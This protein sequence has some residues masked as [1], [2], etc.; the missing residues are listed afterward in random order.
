MSMDAEAALNALKKLEANKTCVNCGN[1]N[2]FGHQNICE[3]VRTFVC[4]NC[5]SAHQSYSMRVKSVSMSNWTMEEVDALRE[6][7]G[8][9][10]AVAAR[11][12]LRRWNDTEM[13][14]PTKDD[15]LDYYKQFINHV[16]NEKAFYSDDGSQVATLNSPTATSSGR[17]AASVCNLLDFDMPDPTNVTHGGVKTTKSSAM[18]DEW[19]AF[20][21]VPVPGSANDG[22]GAFASAPAPTPSISSDC[23]AGTTALRTENDGFGAFASAPAVPPSSSFD[24]FAVPGGTVTTPSV[25]FDPFAPT[26]TQQ[27]QT[28]AS[29]IMNQ[30]NAAPARVDFSVF[31]ALSAP[32]LAYGTPQRNNNGYGQ[33]RGPVG[34]SMGTG[35]NLQQRGFQLQQHLQQQSTMGSPAGRNMGTNYMPNAV[36]AGGYGGGQLKPRDP[37]AGLGLPQK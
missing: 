2:R 32:S 4:S 18:N 6:E 1:Y 26:V 15:S 8:G 30:F 27:R 23:G 11:V 17:S 19:G 28:P 12:W 3:K 34:M 21:A 13:R 22:F 16:Y 37:F 29:N 33:T 36:T 14:K 10:N 7:N 31:D 20:V 5:K 24:A 25:S 35:L 9:G